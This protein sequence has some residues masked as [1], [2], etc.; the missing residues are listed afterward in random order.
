MDPE[1]RLR[2]RSCRQLASG[3]SPSSEGGRTRRLPRVSVQRPET[4]S[5][6]PPSLRSSKNYPPGT[7]PGKS[8]RFP[9]VTKRSWGTTRR[10]S[11]L[12]HAP[13]QSPVL[14][15]SPE[16]G[17]KFA[18]RLTFSQI[19]YPVLTPTP[20]PVFADT[21]PVVGSLDY[22]TVLVFFPPQTPR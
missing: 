4:L 1:H 2:L 10:E 6:K 20:R 9:R 21:F 5:A 22:V 19:S 17:G 13:Q 8:R 14:K 15:T 16:R 7:P 11:D 3:A 12:A 18:A